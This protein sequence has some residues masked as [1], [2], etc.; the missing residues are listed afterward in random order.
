MFLTCFGGRWSILLHRMLFCILFAN[1]SRVDFAQQLEP[2][3]RALEFVPGYPGTH[4]PGVAI[5][6][7]K[8]TL[9]KLVGWSTEGGNSRGIPTFFPGDSDP[10]TLSRDGDGD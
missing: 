5:K 9:G 4:P 8:R 1:L 10:C 7:S 2:G 6:S 3:L